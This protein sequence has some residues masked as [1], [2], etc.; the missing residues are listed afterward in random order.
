MFHWH[1]VISIELHLT[2]LKI[3]FNV[4]FKHIIHFK[5][6]NYFSTIMSLIL[7]GLSIFS[8]L[9]CLML[10][11]DLSHHCS[12]C[13]VPCPVS[14][15]SPCAHLSQCRVVCGR[16]QGPL[17]TTAQVLLTGRQRHHLQ[18]PPAA[19]MSTCSGPQE[20]VAV[21]AVCSSSPALCS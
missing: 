6:G 10:G 11:G 20:P 2:R 8:W 1:A 5:D 17:V 12:N 9:Q 3:T 15:V 16:V 13:S 19:I 4:T 7:C 14:L 18:P 21:P